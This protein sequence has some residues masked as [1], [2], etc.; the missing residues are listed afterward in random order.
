MRL[1]ILD[2]AKADR[3]QHIQREPKGFS[4]PKVWGDRVME[5]PTMK[6]TFVGALIIAAVIIGAAL[7]IRHLRTGNS[8]G[9]E[10]IPT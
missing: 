7:L 3:D 1:Q 2:R 6:I 9:S 4:M 10:Q 8:D 5:E